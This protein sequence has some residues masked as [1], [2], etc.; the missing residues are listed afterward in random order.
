MLHSWIIWRLAKET[1]ED[2][3]KRH[4]TVCDEY[5]RSSCTMN[6]EEQFFPSLSPHDWELSRS[7]HR[8]WRIPDRHI[9]WRIP[10]RHI[11]WQ[12][13]D[14][15]INWWINTTS[16]YSQT[17]FTKTGWSSSLTNDCCSK[18]TT[19][20]LLCRVVERF[21]RAETRDCSLR[22]TGVRRPCYVMWRTTKN[23]TV[24]VTLLLNDT[25]HR[26]ETPISDCHVWWQMMKNGNNGLFFICSKAFVEYS[27]WAGFM[28][29]PWFCVGQV[30]GEHI[31]LHWH[32]YGKT[33]I[34]HWPS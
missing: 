11:N 25:E 26:T 7:R 2:L 13:L 6:E 21:I 19:D 18:N 24:Q 29:N 8:L 5:Y 14:R 15:H 10:D 23:N 22:K 1:L 9:N 34:L 4:A 32:S 31:I 27:D 17:N 33:M 28:E 30:N 3:Q 12:I 16:S 20:V